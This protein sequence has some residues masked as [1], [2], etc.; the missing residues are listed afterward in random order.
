M[1]REIGGQVSITDELRQHIESDCVYCGG[2]KNLL[3]IADCIDAEHGKAL[4]EA[5]RNALANG[6]KR[7]LRQARSASE[8]YRRGCRDTLAGIADTHM[9]LPV[10]ADGVTWT[11]EERVFEEANGRR[12]AMY[13]L[14]YDGERWYVD[15][16][17]IGPDKHHHLIETTLVRH[18]E[19]DTW[20][21]IIA[22][23]LNQGDAQ[24]PAALVAR[25]RALVG[26]TV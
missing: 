14:T 18:A 1:R 16:G 15:C 25:C 20:E 24:D 9:P 6:E 5:I 17:L 22:D 19:P 13:G 8:D 4:H 7:G 2:R 26:E 11:G 10:D 23:A 21:R 12:H 3:N